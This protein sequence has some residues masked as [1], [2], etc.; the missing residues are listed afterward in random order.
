MDKFG[1]GEEVVEFIADHPF[2]FFIEEETAKTTLFV[3][4][5]TN[6]EKA[7][8]KEDKINIEDKISNTD[9]ADKH[10]SSPGA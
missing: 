9:P 2:L 7:Q 10:P 5:V 3:G 4:K 8:V 6:P 1:G